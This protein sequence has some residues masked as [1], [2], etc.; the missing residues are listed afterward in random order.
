MR[1]IKIPKENIYRRIPVKDGG[2][3]VCVYFVF[4]RCSVNDRMIYYSETTFVY[5]SACRCGGMIDVIYADVIECAG[6]SNYMCILL[7][8]QHFL[9]IGPFVRIT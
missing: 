3:R 4:T 2:V 1:D 6:A 7:H 8:V 5:T 9:L